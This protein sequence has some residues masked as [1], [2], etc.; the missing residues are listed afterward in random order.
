L[1]D[2]GRR[3]SSLG[4]RRSHEVT[5]FIFLHRGAKADRHPWFEWKV[6][7]FLAGAAI[8][9]VGIGTGRDWIVAIATFV[10]FVGFVLRFLPGGR[11]I[12][13]SERGRASDPET[14]PPDE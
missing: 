5:A 8:A 1:V 14:S 9:L 2:G 12:W 4:R 6:R 13:D 7:L 10:L 3:A 11:G